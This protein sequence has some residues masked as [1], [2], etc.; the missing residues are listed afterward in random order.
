ML[1]ARNLKPDIFAYI[2]VH[3]YN[4]YLCIYSLAQR[5]KK[6]YIKTWGPLMTQVMVYVQPLIMY[7]LSLMTKYMPFRVLWAVLACLQV[8]DIFPVFN[9]IL[10][11]ILVTCFFFVPETAEIGQQYSI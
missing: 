9:H 4:L 8:L 2:G 6:Y 11:C 1:F 7:I 3:V 10:V 5:N